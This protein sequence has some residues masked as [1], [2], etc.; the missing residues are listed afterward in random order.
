[1][2]I[3]DLLKIRKAKN[4]YIKQWRKDNPEYNKNWHREAYRKDPERFKAYEN[5]YWL[6]K[7]NEEELKKRDDNL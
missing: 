5:K 7:A 1:M 2:K 6:K 3:N 4:A